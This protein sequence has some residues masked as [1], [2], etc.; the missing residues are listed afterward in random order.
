[1]RMEERIATALERIADTLERMAEEEKEQTKQLRI[2][3]AKT[4]MS[5]RRP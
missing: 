3:A 5:P 1:M 2:I 4:G